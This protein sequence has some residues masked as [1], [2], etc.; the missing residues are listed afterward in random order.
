MD[1]LTLSKQAHLYINEIK[2]KVCNYEDMNVKENFDYTPFHY[3]CEN[4]AYA[5]QEIYND[6]ITFFIINGA[7]IN[8]YNWFN[9]SPFYF[10]CKNIYVSIKLIK[11]AYEYNA[12]IHYKTIE[13]KTIMH[14]ICHNYSADVNIVNYIMSIGGDKYINSKDND[15]NTPLHYIC[16]NKNL[17]DINLISLFIKDI[18]IK[19]KYENT[20][21]CYLCSNW[22]IN[23]PV[24]NY[25]IKNGADIN[26]KNCYDNIPFHYLCKN[27][28]VTYK[29]LKKFLNITNVNYKNSD[30]ITPLHYL[31]ENNKNTAIIKNVF[32]YASNDTVI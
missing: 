9:E 15:F 31:T 26:V 29:M 32:K 17:L 6:L 14:S 16:Q 21:F 1:L 4:S 10:I 27:T 2:A 25:F 5:S 20:P 30:N 18:N 3:I 23:Y 11:L 12:D 19:N 24:L 28:K 22:S 8:S 13:N 7:H